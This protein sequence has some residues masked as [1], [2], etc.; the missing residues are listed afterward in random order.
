[1]DMLGEDVIAQV[2]SHTK[3]VNLKTHTKTRKKLSDADSVLLGAEESSIV[4][5]KLVDMSVDSLDSQNATKPKSSRNSVR[6]S[7]PVLGNTSEGV[8]CKFCEVEVSTQ[9]VLNTVA[10]PSGLM[11]VLSSLANCCRGPAWIQNMQVH[12]CPNCK[13]VLGRGR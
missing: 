13:L 8:F 1:M 2:A 12:Q 10:L 6:E 4:S 5:K 3:T 11:K 7:L 9:V